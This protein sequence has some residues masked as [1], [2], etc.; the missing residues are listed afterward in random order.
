MAYSPCGRRIAAASDI[1]CAD[2]TPLALKETRYDLAGRVSEELTYDVSDY[3]GDTFTVVRYSY[4]GRGL[5]V[6]QQSPNGPTSRSIYDGRGRLN[7]ITYGARDLIQSS[8]YDL[9]DRM[10]ARGLGNG[11]GSTY[12][13][14]ANA[15][16]QQ[17]K[18]V[19]DVLT[20]EQIGYGYDT[21]PGPVG[22]D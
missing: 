13:Y 8:T 2:P 7:G 9:A 4:D 1:L 6:E 12:T 18:H 20:L 14:D 11:I 16:V 19:K 22:A 21:D 5:V 3:R 15:W 10:T 17:I